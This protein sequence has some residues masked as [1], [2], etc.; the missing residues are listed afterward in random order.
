MVTP[1]SPG[2]IIRSPVYLAS[3]KNPSPLECSYILNTK[4]VDLGVALTFPSVDLQKGLLQIVNGQIIGPVA[5][6]YTGGYPNCL[7]C[8]T[9]L[10][11]SLYFKTTHGTQKRGLILQAILK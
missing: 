10:Q 2:G 9:Q 8:G 7:P 11:W 3:A 4:S 1:D 6:N 5:R